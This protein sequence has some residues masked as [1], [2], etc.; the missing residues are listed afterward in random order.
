MAETRSLK[1][2]ADARRDVLRTASRLK[3]WWLVQFRGY[4]VVTAALEPRPCFLGGIRYDGQ[5]W[6][7]PRLV[8]H[9]VG[10]DFGSNEHV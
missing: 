8:A 7:A 9:D 1:N 2:E 5:W 10:A 6:L 3:V 4:R